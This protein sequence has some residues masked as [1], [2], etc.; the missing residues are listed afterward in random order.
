[1][2]EVILEP[3]IT[4]TLGLQR[5]DVDRARVFAGRNGWST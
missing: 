5:D 1:M 4:A 2:G 3:R